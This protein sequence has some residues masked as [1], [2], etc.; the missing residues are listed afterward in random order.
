MHVVAGAD[1]G[2]A[3]R[4]RDRRTAADVRVELEQVVRTWLAGIVGRAVAGQTLT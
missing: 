2:F 3:V 4:R 1:H